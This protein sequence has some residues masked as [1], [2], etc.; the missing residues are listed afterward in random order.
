MIFGALRSLRASS[1]A[2]GVASS[3]KMQIGRRLD[4]DVRGFERV[5]FLQD[6]AKAT[7]KPFPIPDTR[8]SLKN[9]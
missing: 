2:M 8:V 9:P 1:K 6:G 5:F 4:G 7:G 3:P